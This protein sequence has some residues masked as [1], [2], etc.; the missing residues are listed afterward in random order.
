[1]YD[2][3]YIEGT[4][5]FRV[6]G[7][8]VTLF[9]AL[10]CVSAVLSC[11]LMAYCFHK[12]KVHG[13][14]GQWFCLFSLVLGTFFG[15]FVYALTRIMH[16]WDRGPAA[17]LD[18]SYGG[19]L[20]FGVFLGIF[21]AACLAK[22]VS[23][24]KMTWQRLL[25]AALPAVFLFVALVRF[26][27]PADKQGW[28]EWVSV[29]DMPVQSF[30]PL[31]FVKDPEWATPD[32]TEWYYSIFMLEGLWALGLCVYFMLPRSYQKGDVHRLVLAMILYCAAQVAFEPMRRDITVRWLF[33]RASQVFSAVTL[34]VL[35][36]VYMVKRRRFTPM[37]LVF[38]VFTG[39]CI[40]LEFAV[41]KPLILGD[42]RIFFPN[43]L[44]YVLEAVCAGMMGFATY[45]G[46]IGYKEHTITK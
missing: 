8:P 12:R 10:V 40:A 4:E 34:A 33:V 6:F 32:W 18:P 9:S 1:M 26:S 5:L 45:K 2:G 38:L 29:N 14:T 41:D 17:F 43:A 46:T 30:F 28:G 20:F 37:F 11:A 23:R 27:E 16:F 31:A 19:F 3:G 39:G 13:E 35:L 15:H 24:G 44:V 21:L 36:I 22:A 7:R 25:S 42:R